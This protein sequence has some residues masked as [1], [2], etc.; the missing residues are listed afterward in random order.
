MTSFLNVPF[1]PD[2]RYVEFL[3]QCAADLDSVHFSLEHE[4]ALDSRVRVATV[5]G[6]DHLAGLAPRLPAAGCRRGGRRADLG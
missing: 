5:R 2:G 6:T 1:L 4:P 3:E